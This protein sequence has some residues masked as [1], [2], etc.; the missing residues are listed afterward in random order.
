MYARNVVTIVQHLVQRTKGP[1]GKPTGPPAL[2][3]NPEDE[4]TREILVTRDGAIVHAR[5]QQLAGVS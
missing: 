1:D 4:I 5:M 3:L 2:V